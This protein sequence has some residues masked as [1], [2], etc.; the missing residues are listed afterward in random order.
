MKSAA[1]L[2]TLLLPVGAAAAE[3]QLSLCVSAA[4]ASADAVAT[5]DRWVATARVEAVAP[6]CPPPA[7]ERYV[8]RFERHGAAI[9]FRLAAPDGSSL[10]RAVP[11]LQDVAA[12][13]PE[14]ARS[15]RLSE[16][17]VLVEGL[18]AEHRL[19]AAWA[20]PPPPAAPPPAAPQKAPP[21]RKPPPKRA[22]RPK[23]KPRP[24]PEVAS[25]APPP[26]PTAPAEPPRPADP[27]EPPPGP[28]PA[29]AA[30]ASAP[31]APAP[32]LP[33]ATAP[34][35]QLDFRAPSTAG[36]A[37]RL[38]GAAG[39]RVRS[40]GFAAPELGVAAEL[41]PGWLR[42]GWQPRTRWALAGLPI[43]IEA[44]ALEAGLQTSLVSGRLWEFRGLAGVAVERL[45]LMPLYVD[46]PDRVANWDAGPLLGGRLGWA[47]LD[48]F[49][50]ALA[51]AVQ[52]MPTARTSHVGE[53]G[54][55]ARVNAVAGRL[56]LE[57][58]WPR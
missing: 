3:T 51:A 41:G 56:A 5:L 19:M 10:E 38:A 16:F 49:G 43:G 47:P 54:P 52:W 27:V 40:P 2:A 42:A 28:A 31:P 57:I 33:V 55:S 17:S 8:G 21:R 7:P 26:L 18:L 30:P 32:R 6:P 20:P 39:V 11:W 14:L 34:P 37:L 29:E 46:S 50:L 22:T 36:P 25:A 35:A 4:A 12:P 15:E 24:A 9:F 23:A 13:L 53:T 44:L 48:S 1:L 45:E 58:A